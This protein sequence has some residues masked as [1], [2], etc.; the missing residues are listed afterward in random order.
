MLPGGFIY[1][2]NIWEHLYVSEVGKQN[3]QSTAYNPIL[4]QNRAYSLTQLLSIA[5]RLT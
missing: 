5:Y 4:H 2:L 1:S 3:E